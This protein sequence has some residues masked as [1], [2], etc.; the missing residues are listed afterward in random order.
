MQSL[1]HGSYRDCPVGLISIDWLWREWER[2][3]RAGRRWHPRRPRPRRVC[4]VFGFL[5]M[6]WGRVTVF[7]SSFHVPFSNAT[8]SEE[9]LEEHIQHREKLHGN[10][11]HSLTS[12]IFY[13]LPEFCTQAP[14][15]SKRKLAR[16]LL[17][18][19]EFGKI[20]IYLSVT[21]YQK[22]AS[23]H[24]WTLVDAEHSEPDQRI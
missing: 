18:K 9:I 4:N 8:P 21:C 13:F 10:P 17:R 14:T 2:G 20:G 6:R 19:I 24:T 11:P 12:H 15:S 23:R 7:F 1:I 22:F 5:S 16:I 3:R